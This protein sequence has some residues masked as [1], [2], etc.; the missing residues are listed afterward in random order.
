MRTGCLQLLRF[1]GELLAKVAVPIRH[2]NAVYW[3]S[4]VS[5]PL[6]QPANSS[7]H[8]PHTVRT[9]VDRTRAFENLHSP[10]R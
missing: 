6:L 9:C 1:I 3:L 2:V 4:K 7:M 5:R 10:R 8:A